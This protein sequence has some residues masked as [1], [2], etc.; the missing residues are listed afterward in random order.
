M[1]LQQIETAVGAFRPYARKGRLRQRPY[2]GNKAH[3][4]IEMVLERMFYSN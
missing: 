2:N 3:L 1:K 4:H